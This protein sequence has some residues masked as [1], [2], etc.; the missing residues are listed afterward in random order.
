MQ[1]GDRKRVRNRTSKVER[2]M[3]DPDSNETSDALLLLYIKYNVKSEISLGKPIPLYP[4]GVYGS[5]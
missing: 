3:L 4:A 5:R 1:C 2:Q